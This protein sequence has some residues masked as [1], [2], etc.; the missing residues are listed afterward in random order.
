M[1][2]KKKGKHLKEQRAQQEHKKQSEARV[3]WLRIHFEER[4]KDAEAL[5]LPTIDDF[6]GLDD[7]DRK[8]ALDH[9]LG[10]TLVEAEAVF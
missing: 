7:G 5:G 9:F 1:S 3:R 4:E 8:Y 6:G 2:G 10:K